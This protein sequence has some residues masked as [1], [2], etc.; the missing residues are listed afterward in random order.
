MKFFVLETQ[1]TSS[2]MSSRSAL[3]F[4]LASLI[5]YPKI[6]SHASNWAPGGRALQ[7]N[8]S[9]LIYCLQA[10]HSPAANSSILIHSSVCGCASSYLRHPEPQFITIPSFL[11]LNAAFSRTMNGIDISLIL[12]CSTSPHFH[13]DLCDPMRFCDSHLLL[14]SVHAARSA[15]QDLIEDVCEKKTIRT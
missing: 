8:D 4:G 6:L 9:G 2:P 7:P 10:E 11:I 14:L 5:G 13:S 3:G 1:I 12:V 15:E